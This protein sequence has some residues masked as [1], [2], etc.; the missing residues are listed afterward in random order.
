MCS[1]LYHTLARSRAKMTPVSLERQGRYLAVP[2]NL[3]K[4]E[5]AIALPVIR[6]LASSVRLRLLLST[7]TVATLILA[8]QE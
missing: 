1:L 6:T 5:G 8:N 7:G 3:L 4:E 2:H